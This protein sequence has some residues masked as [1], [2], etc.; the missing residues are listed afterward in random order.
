M[1]SGAPHLMIGAFYLTVNPKMYFTFLEKNYEV[2]I[3]KYIILN[4]SF[5]A[6]KS[7]NREDI[8]FQVLRG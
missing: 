4:M 1:I 6:V 3:V 2:M 8:I 5:S 7:A